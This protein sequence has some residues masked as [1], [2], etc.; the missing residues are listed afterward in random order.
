MYIHSVDS[1]SLIVMFAMG[2]TDFGVMQFL[3]T[4]NMCMN[5]LAS[6]KDFQVTNPSSQGWSSS[7]FLICCCYSIFIWTYNLLFVCLEVYNVCGFLSCCSWPFVNMYTIMHIL[8]QLI[9]VCYHTAFFSFVHLFSLS[10]FSFLISTASVLCTYFSHVY[11]C[12]YM[13]MYIK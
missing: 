6:H 4:K 1:G 12:T 10:L 13:Y 7:A 11:T 9:H 8:V 3:V 5:M 2:M